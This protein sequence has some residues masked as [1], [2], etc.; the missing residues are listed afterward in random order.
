MEQTIHPGPI[1]GA[2][3]P[4]CSKS[5][6]QRALAASLLCAGESSLHNLE[7]CDDTCSAIRCIEALGA[8]VERRGERSLTI[9]GGLRPVT[10]CLKVG[11]S[12]LSARLFTPI[13]ALCDRPIRIEGEGS[14]L[15]RP[16]EMML[17]PLRALGATVHDCDGR[18]PIEVCGPMRGGEVT[19]DGSISSQFT[20]GLLL[21]LP[22]LHGESLVRVENPVSTPYIDITID[23][24]RR[25]GVEIAR[26][27]YTQFYFAP[28]QA[29]QPTE[30]AIESDWSA[31]AMLLVAGAVAGEVALHGLP[32]YSCQADRA[33]LQAL[34]RAGAAVVN[35]EEKI[36][37]AQRPLTAFAFDATDCPDLFPALTV[38]AVAAEGVS[39]L[40]GVRRLA[41][42]ESDRAEVLQREFGRLGV[43]IT[44]EGD[45]MRI[46]GGAIRGG[47]VEAHDDHRIAM[48]LAVAALIAEAPV[49]IAGAECVSKSYPD[50]FERLAALRTI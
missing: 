19:V 45:E 50:F 14:L 33:V 34:V 22:T 12:G 20:T 41:H 27:G 38:L 47:R 48:A 15:Q 32:P 7:F 16:M 5:Y 21:A 6:A 17:A 29:Y 24:A 49:T 18:L 28:E 4:P 42:K 31:A 46:R 9:R 39:C 11:A 40:R 3:T 1:R 26:E 37:V 36:T 30:L 35:E 43:E 10:D 8:Q 25:F 13:A 23:L 44:I 2:L